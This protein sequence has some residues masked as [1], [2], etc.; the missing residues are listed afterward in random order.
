MIDSVMVSSV[1]DAAVSG[2][3]LV[4]TVNLLLIYLFNAIAV[5]GA[6]VVSQLIGKGDVK[7]ANEASK[8]L[9]WAITIIATFVSIVVVFLRSPLLKLIFG[10][11]ENDVM[12]HAQIYFL[13]TSISFPF[14]AVRSASASVFRAGGDSKFS[15]K[16]SLLVNAI[17]IG[18]NALLIYVAKIGVAGA[19]ISTLVAR[20]VGAV[21][22]VFALGDTRRLV[23]VE[24]LFKYKPDLAYIKNIF[25]IG[26][27]NGLENGMFQFGKVL[28]QS[29]ISTLGTVCIAANAVSGTLTSMQYIPGTAIG[30]TML[31]VIGRCIGAGEKEQAKYYAKTLL[32]VGY[33]C[34]ATLSLIM[35]I[36]APQLVS[37]YNISPES[38]DIA[39]KI[40]RIHSIVVSTIWPIAFPLS[41]AF[42]ATSDVKFTMVVAI[43]SMWT[44]RVGLSYVFVLL[45]N[46]SVY[47][48]W[49]A[50]FCDWFARFIIFG[51]RF[52]KGTWLTKYKPIQV[53]EQAPKENT[54]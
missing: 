19:A 4:D 41:S 1:G 18:G 15:L 33:A 25:G 53:K 44:L 7:Q 29:L 40:I 47:G 45:F 49:F 21:I 42:R 6:V 28:T 38:A 13:I 50:M 52:L 30:S 37:L 24:K 43:I 51:I 39:V 48:V 17:N 10:K 34:I 32:G 3:S 46:L 14:L 35:A 54:T 23:Y 26:I 12:Q 9:M 5:G 8:Q 20:I 36:F 2:V 16:I 27:P 31:I 22:S 11:V